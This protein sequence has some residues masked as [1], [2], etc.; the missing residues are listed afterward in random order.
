MQ[1]S[2]LINKDD[3]KGELTCI[4]LSRSPFHREDIGTAKYINY[5]SIFD[6]ESGL[7]LATKNSLNLC[8][9]EY[10]TFCD[11]DDPFTDKVVYPIK[12]LVYGDFLI[13]QNNEIKRIISNRWS[14]SENLRNYWII[15]KP[16]MRTEQAKDLIRNMEPLDI[17]FH[18]VF[19]FM[20]HYC[21]GGEY[22]NRLNF[23]WNKGLEGMHKS[24]YL[25]LSSA[26]KWLLQ[27]ATNLRNKIVH[28]K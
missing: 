3:I 5:N 6:N 14:F 8:S 22:D 21:Y 12:G 25:R 15:H 20:M 4:T 19:Y 28:C 7:F 1:L 18:Y 11:H 27:N 10:C 23:V 26:K 13:N 16:I 24:S 17:S 9:T 2:P